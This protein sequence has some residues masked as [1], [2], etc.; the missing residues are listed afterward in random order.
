MIIDST[1]NGSVTTSV[2]LLMLRTYC[3]TKDDPYFLDLLRQ[4]HG[5]DACGCR[6]PTVQFRSQHLSP[7]SSISR[8]LL[9]VGFALVMNILLYHYLKLY[10]IFVAASNSII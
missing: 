1:A 4:S 7:R 8:T 10:A 5:D 2:R 6:L 3:D 9:V